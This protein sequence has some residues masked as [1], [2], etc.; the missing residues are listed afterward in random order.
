[1][2]AHA[3]RPRSTICCGTSCVSGSA[4][5]NS[6]DRDALS[7]LAELIRC[8]SVTPDAGAALDVVEKYLAAAGFECHRLTF[9]APGTEPVD[10]LFARLG[11]G[12]PHLCFAGHAD[13]VPPGDQT[14]WSAPPFAAQ[15]RDGR[16]VGRGAEDMKGAVAAALAAALELVAGGTPINGSLSFLITGDEEG[17]S[18]NG[19]RPVL[20]WMAEHSHTP[21]ECI[22]GEPTNTGAIGDAIKIG[23]RGALTGTLV[24]TGEQGHS[25][26]PE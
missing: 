25:A 15:I 20:E 3:P 8:P 4:G 1:M 26:Y 2:R 22:V 24:V 17:P 13:V 18:V 10:N 21:D 7:I 11:T 5:G 19:T 12:R 6:G 14:R 16:I 23:R 9:E